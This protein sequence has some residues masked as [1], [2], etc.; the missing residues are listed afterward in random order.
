MMEYNAW[1]KRNLLSVLS[2]TE[3]E[4]SISGERSEKWDS[5]NQIFKTEYEFSRSKNEKRNIFNA[6]Q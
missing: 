4:W 6:N 1:N 5:Q 2:G 3:D